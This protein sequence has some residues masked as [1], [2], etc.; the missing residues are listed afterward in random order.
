MLRGARFVK[1]QFSSI[2]DV[3]VLPEQAI[4]NCTNSSSTSLFEE[5]SLR[6]RHYILLEFASSGGLGQQGELVLK[7]KEGEN[8]FELQCLSGRT[9]LILKS[10]DLLKR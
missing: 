7:G 8:E 2:Q 4:W 5:P 6:Q 1:K 10:E 3:L 9:V